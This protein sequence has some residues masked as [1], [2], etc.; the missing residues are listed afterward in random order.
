MCKI[1]SHVLMFIDK[2]NYYNKYK[3]FFKNEWLNIT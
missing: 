1:I 3:L 2:I